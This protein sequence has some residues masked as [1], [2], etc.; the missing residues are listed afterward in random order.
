MVDPN[1]FLKEDDVADQEML[2][3]GSE[4]ETE[5]SLSESILDF[6]PEAREE[7]TGSQHSRGS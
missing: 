7:D 5:P 3:A 4:T 6:E 1:G 2:G